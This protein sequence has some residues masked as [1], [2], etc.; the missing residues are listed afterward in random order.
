VAILPKSIA[1]PKAV[2]IMFFS[3]EIGADDGYTPNPNRQSK[4]KLNTTASK[5]KLC[6]ARTRF[7]HLMMTLK[8]TYNL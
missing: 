5:I 8:I 2:K 4:A 6:R 1:I 3:R 7:Y